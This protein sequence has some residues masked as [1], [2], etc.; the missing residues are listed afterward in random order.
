MPHR[1]H[2]LSLYLDVTVRASASD[3]PSLT[4]ARLSQCLPLMGSDIFLNIAEHDGCQTSPF[5]E[6]AGQVTSKF[7]GC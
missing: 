5:L 7:K 2:F 4:I 3:L 6:K 1:Y